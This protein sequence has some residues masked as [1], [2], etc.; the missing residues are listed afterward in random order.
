MSLS[1]APTFTPGSTGQ[2]KIELT[3]L[4]ANNIAVEVTLATME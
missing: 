3:N 4:D 1:A 2:Y